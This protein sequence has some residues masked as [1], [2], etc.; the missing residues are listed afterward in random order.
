MAAPPLRPVFLLSL[1]RSGSTLVQR[2]LAAHATVATVPEPW[3]VLPQVYALR[4]AGV[5]AEY[6]HRSLAGAVRGF[7]RRLPGG[8][9]TYH[10][11]VRT[12]LLSLYTEAAPAGTRWFVDKTPRY[13]LI[14]D[15]L[16]ALFPDAVLILLWRNPLAVLA[17]MTTTWDR[18][19]WAPCR[20]GIDLFSGMEQLTSAAERLAD[21]VTTVRYEDLVASPKA[22]RPIFDRLGIGFDEGV[23]A[24]VDEFQIRGRFGD[25]TQ[26]RRTGVSADP[27]ET[28]R[29]VLA[30][31]VRTRWCRRYLDWL[32][33]ER[34]SG[35]GYDHAELVT[36]L[37]QIATR[38]SMAARDRIRGAR[39]RV[40]VAVRR[41]QGVG[42]VHREW[43]IPCWPWTA[44]A[45]VWR[46]DPRVVARSQS[47][48]W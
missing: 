17:S 37:D 19:L 15:E 28:W 33:P 38:R 23:L 11:H 35:M 43:P 26:G 6:D 44:P 42:P 29:D 3:L 18:G 14:V 36:D 30:S 4:E 5:D 47:T 48:D 9:D 39:E 13:H 21:R 45:P 22:W 32:G 41:W 27:L 12:L 10:R 2:V 16:A 25:P 20:H 31:P 46:R 34:L 24:S 40:R 1:P 8:V 7:A